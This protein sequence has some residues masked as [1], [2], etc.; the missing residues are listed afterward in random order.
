MDCT[1][2]IGCILCN[3]KD[4]CDEWV[5]IDSLKCE[6]CDTNCSKRGTCESCNYNAEE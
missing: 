2:I 4:T 5:C 1:N 6:Q 3:N